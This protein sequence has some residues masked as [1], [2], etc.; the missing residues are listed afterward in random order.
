MPKIITLHTN[1]KK[2]AAYDIFCFFLNELSKLTTYI[3]TLFTHVS[4]AL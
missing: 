2:V 4:L 1:N 3:Y